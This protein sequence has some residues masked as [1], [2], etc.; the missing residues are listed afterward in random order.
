VPAKPNVTSNPA[1]SAPNIKRR[2]TETISWDS[3]PTSLIKSGKV[4][5][6][7]CGSQAW[8]YELNVS[9]VYIFGH[10]KCKPWFWTIHL[11]TKRCTSYLWSLEKKNLNHAAHSFLCVNRPLSGGRLLLL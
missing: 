5:F 10:M 6:S 4:Y 2:V 8:I 9:S 7:F 11:F 3:L 1:P